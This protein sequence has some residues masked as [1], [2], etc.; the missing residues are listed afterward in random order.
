[1]FAVLGVIV[2]LQVRCHGQQAASKRE[3]GDFPLDLQ[4][5]LQQQQQ[6]L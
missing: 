6:L 3:Q 2:M 1:M 4:F 5:A